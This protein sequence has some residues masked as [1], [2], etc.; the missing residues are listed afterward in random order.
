MLATS[1]QPQGVQHA[2]ASNNVTQPSIIPV[3]P[4]Q[5]SLEQS[6]GPA[7]N[8]QTRQPFA[9]NRCRGVP[10]AV[11]SIPKTLLNILTRYSFVFWYV[12]SNR[13]A[14]RVYAWIYEPQYSGLVSFNISCFWILL[15]VSC[16]QCY[17]ILAHRAA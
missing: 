12:V 11:R 3:V 9:L 7:W 17:S 10:E 13:A 2:F 15:D 6:C 16:A 5:F 1:A 8:P 14:G 4:R